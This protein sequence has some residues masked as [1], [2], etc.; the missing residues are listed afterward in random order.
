MQMYYLFKSET[1]PRLQA[2]TDESTGSRLPVEQGPWT[3]IR[4]VSPDDTDWPHTTT[5]EVVATGVAANGFLLLTAEGSGQPSVSSK[6]VIESDRVEGTAVYDPNGK[7]IGTI[8]RLMIEKVSGRVTYAVMTFGGFL[9]IG[10]HEHTI[11]WNKLDYDT[12][13]GGYRTD[14]T[15]EQLRGAPTVFGEGEVWPDRT[16]EREVHDY[17]RIPPYWGGL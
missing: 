7:H 6:P 15:E 5:R 9:G 10:S 4:Q 17:W 12:R 13:L 1:D 11:P 8:K 2:F 14:I 3:L 16:R